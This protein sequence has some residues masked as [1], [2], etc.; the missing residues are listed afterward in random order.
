M[1]TISRSVLVSVSAFLLGSASGAPHSHWRNPYLESEK[2]LYADYLKQ[3]VLPRL[4]ES[5]PPVV[6]LI[7]WDAPDQ[8]KQRPDKCV[9]QGWVL[10]G[11]PCKKMR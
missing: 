10:I 1:G 8:L 5:S 6:T 11:R 9:G 4:V 2:A 7:G 3:V